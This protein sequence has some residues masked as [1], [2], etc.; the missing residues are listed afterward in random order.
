MRIAWSAPAHNFQ[1]IDAYYIEIQD[2]AA[3][4]FYEESTYCD[5]SDSG[6]VSQLYCEIPLL[7]TLREAPYNLEVGDSVI[8]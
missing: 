4:A 5:G 8:V 2:K 7:T 3:S 1:T 6:I